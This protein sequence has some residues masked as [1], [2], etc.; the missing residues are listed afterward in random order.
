MVMASVSISRPYFWMIHFSRPVRTLTPEKKSKIV[1]SCLEVYYNNNGNRDVWCR[2]NFV[3]LNSRRTL[4]NLDKNCIKFW[5]YLLGYYT[6]TGNDCLFQI[7]TTRYSWWYIYFNYLLFM[8]I[9]LSHSSL[10]AYGSNICNC[11]NVLNNLTVKH[12][13][14]TS[15]LDQRQNERCA[16]NSCG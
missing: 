12:H 2:G 15:Y 7:L 16:L 5:H 4:S 1:Y 14:E 13:Q 6:E 9:Y 11:N 8:M 3:Y 10:Y